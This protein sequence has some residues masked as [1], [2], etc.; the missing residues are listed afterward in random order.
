LRSNRGS[1]SLASRRGWPSAAKRLCCEV[2]KAATLILSEPLRLRHLPYPRYRAAEEDIATHQPHSLEKYAYPQTHIGEYCYVSTFN[3]AQLHAH[4][5][6]TPIRKY[7]G[8]NI[9]A[10]QPHTQT[11]QRVCQLHQLFYFLRCHCSTLNINRYRRMSSSVSP[12]QWRYRGSGSTEPKGLAVSR[13]AAL[14]RGWKSCDVDS[15]Q[16]PPFSSKTPPLSALS[17]GRGG[18]CYVSPF[19]IQLPYLLHF[20][21]THKLHS[22]FASFT[23]I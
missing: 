20:N 6:H 2:G 4:R 11:S 1:G 5:K 15:F 13:K 16:T 3:S 14:L 22:A 19:A 8:E 12:C 10:L 17:C 21:R 7:T 23:G 9:A 18:H